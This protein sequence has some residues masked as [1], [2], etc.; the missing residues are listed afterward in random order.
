MG[1]KSVW[2][3]TTHQSNLNIEEM[4]SNPQFAMETAKLVSKR[5]VWK[6]V[7]NVID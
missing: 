6:P 5:Q 4:R 2:A 3:P 1:G 7:R